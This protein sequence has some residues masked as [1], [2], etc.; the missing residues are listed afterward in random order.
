MEP[1][2]IIK[3]HIA[4]CGLHCGGCFAFNGGNIQKHSTEL[5]KS[6]G[7]FDVYAQRFVTMLDE[8]VFENYQSFKMMLH[9]FSETKCNGC[10][11]QACALFKSCH[12]RDCFREKGVDFC[13]QCTSFPCEQT[14]FDEHLQKR[15]ISINEKIRKIGIENYYEEIKDVPRY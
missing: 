8:P 7:N 12:V 4:P 10:R 6:L 14:G 5:I 9:Y 13:F 2:G 1:N 11:E 15:F 3:K